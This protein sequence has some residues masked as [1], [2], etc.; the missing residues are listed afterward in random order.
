[1]WKTHITV[2]DSICRNIS[3]EITIGSTF[4]KEEILLAYAIYFIH[5]A[6]PDWFI[7]RNIAVAANY[8]NVFNISIRNL[9][10]NC[11]NAY[12]GY[13]MYKFVNK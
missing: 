4:I 5:G 2:K 9:V 13:K 10:L 6:G 3:R 12:L 7:S 1:M 8:K 11:Y